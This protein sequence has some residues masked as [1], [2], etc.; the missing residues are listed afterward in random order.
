MHLEAFRSASKEI[1]ANNAF[2]AKKRIYESRLCERT[3]K[4]TKNL[5]NL[6]VD[7]PL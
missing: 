7:S 3:R 5:I 1:E 4:E 6:P 2:E